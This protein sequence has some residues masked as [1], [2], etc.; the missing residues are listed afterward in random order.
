VTLAAGADNA[1]VEIGGLKSTPPANWKD[2]A[3]TSQLQVKAFTL[4]GTEGGKDDATLTVYFF[5]G[6]GG[7]VEENVKRWK[8]M[9]QP[10][11]GKNIDDVAKTE[12]LTVGGAKVTVLDVSGTYLFKAR[13]MDTQAEPRPD[14]RMLAVFFPTAK[15]PYYMRLVG[16]AKTV[17]AHEKGFL[18]WLK[19]FK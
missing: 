4:P 16:P 10:P 14:H 17:A 18:E 12:E 7:G 5:Q 6:Q 8:G 11:A 2:K 15:G 3:T 9:F 19:N 1:P 13:P